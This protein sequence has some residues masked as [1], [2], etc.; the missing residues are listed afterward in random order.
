[1]PI[2][3]EEESA[4]TS[5]GNLPV[6]ELI[7]PS[8]GGQVTSLAITQEQVTG[9]TKIDS[10]LISSNSDKEGVIEDVFCPELTITSNV[11]P[12]LKQ[13]LIPPTTGSHDGTSIGIKT[14]GQDLKKLSCPQCNFQVSSSRL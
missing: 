6:P 12:V 10:A 5:K 2:S 3:V 9:V 14:S 13:F 8:V 7:I 1:M 11:K 4:G